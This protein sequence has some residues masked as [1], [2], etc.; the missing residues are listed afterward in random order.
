MGNDLIWV[1]RESI[2]QDILAAI[3][4]VENPVLLVAPRRQLFT[5]GKPQNIGLC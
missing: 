2:P 3:D 1:P 5:M 4:K